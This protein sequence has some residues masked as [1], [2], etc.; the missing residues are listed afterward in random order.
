VVGQGESFLL[1]GIC[2]AADYLIIKNQLSG[3]FKNANDL[4]KIYSF[5]TKSVIYIIFINKMFLC[6]FI[7]LDLY[8]LRS[9]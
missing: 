7:V 9:F 3:W 4:L 8:P 5:I 1:Q 6:F 2:L